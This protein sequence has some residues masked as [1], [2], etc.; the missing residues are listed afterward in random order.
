MA[1]RTVVE[2]RDIDCITEKV[3]I[4]DAL[5]RDFGAAPVKL[6]SLRRGNEGEQSALLVIPSVTARKIVGKGRLRVGLISCRVRMS[7]R[8]PRC[9][10]CLAFAHNVRQ[11]KDSPNRSDC[12]NRCGTK[13][14]QAKACTA[15]RGEADAF[16]KILQAETASTK[17]SQ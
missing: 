9:F 10:K 3:E 16:R 8:R 11:C 15:S 12:C 4:R 2:V 6:L 5:A 7:N 1:E 17:D 14:H 13:G